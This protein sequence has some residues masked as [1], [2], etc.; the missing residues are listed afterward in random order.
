MQELDWDGS[1][2]ISWG[3]WHHTPISA[4]ALLGE[5]ESYSSIP[6]T[7]ILPHFCAVAHETTCFLTQFLPQRISRFSRKIHPSA[8]A[9]TGKKTPLFPQQFIPQGTPVPLTVLSTY[10]TQWVFRRP[11]PPPREEVV[12]WGV[13]RGRAGSRSSRFRHGCRVMERGT[14]GGK[15]RQTGLRGRTQ[16]QETGTEGAGVG[17]SWQVVRQAHGA[18]SEPTEREER[19]GQEKEEPEM[20]SLRLGYR[21]LWCDWTSQT[22][23]QTLNSKCWHSRSHLKNGFVLVNHYHLIRSLIKR[24]EKFHLKG[25]AHWYSNYTL[26]QPQVLARSPPDL[27]PNPT[28][29]G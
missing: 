2:W 3:P 12:H 17:I 11:L 26:R 25:V 24:K 5:P 16:R 15:D 21:L 7:R 23:C 10:R 28:D 1:E 4:L 20:Q 9:Q 6:T 18:F 22:H 14:P 8:L 19:G 13:C 27:T 29:Q